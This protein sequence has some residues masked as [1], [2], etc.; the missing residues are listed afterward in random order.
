MS[1]W[2][3]VD[4]HTKLAQFLEETIYGMDRDDSEQV[5]YRILELLEEEEDG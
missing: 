1:N 5:A 3:E 4:K 2:G